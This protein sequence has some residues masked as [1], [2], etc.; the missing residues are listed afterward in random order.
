[1]SKIVTF[2]GEPPEGTINF[3]V[4]QPS[5]DLLPMDLVQKATE[6]FFQAAHPLN[7]NYGV[8]QGDARFR[9]SLATL[10]EQRTMANQLM[11]TAFL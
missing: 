10:L 8:L 7:L 3:G 4:G 1:M 6:D 5:P 9:D 11:P 2:E